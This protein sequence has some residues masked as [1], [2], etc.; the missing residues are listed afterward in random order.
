MATQKDK[1]ITK[2]IFRKYKDT[3]D[4]LALFP[5]EVEHNGLVMCYQ[6]V[7]Q[8]G[9]ADYHHCVRM[10][11]LATQEEAKDLQAELEDLG[12]NLNVGKK[13]YYNQYLAA[14]NANFK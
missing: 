1:H 12:Y 13:I 8:H 3:K 14:Y 2:V 9:S 10:T 7:G 5:Y 6:H 4:I 11:T